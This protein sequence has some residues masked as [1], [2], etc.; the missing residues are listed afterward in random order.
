MN[1]LTPLALLATISLGSASDPV[2]GP[3]GVYSVTT[4]G[5]TRVTS[6]EGW[7]K[8]EWEVEPVVPTPPEPAKPVEPPPV[9]TPPPAP[10]PSGPAVSI[11]V[12]TGQ[13]FMLAVYDS[14]KASS[15]PPAQQAILLP[16]E[17][18][19]SASIAAAL[20]AREIF[21]RPRDQSDPGLKDWVA[22][23]Q[24]KG[25]PAVV[26]IGDAGKTSFVVPLPADGTGVLELAKK[27]R[28]EG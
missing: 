12:L 15:Y 6:G 20:K 17:K 3:A 18:G 4:T 21:W 10:A 16:P 9:V 27:I 1:R 2:K 25:L 7:V 13:V 14:T 8:I 24:A 19:G 11:P 22:D 26:V 23:A 28:G 5:P